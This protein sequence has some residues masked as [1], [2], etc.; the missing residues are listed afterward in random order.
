MR[1]N[2][3]EQE[4]GVEVLEPKVRVIR[5]K[6]TV[7]TTSLKKKRNLFGWCADIPITMIAN[8]PLAQNKIRDLA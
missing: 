6:L 2:E 5:K 3:Q 7:E 8:M 4:Q 1:T